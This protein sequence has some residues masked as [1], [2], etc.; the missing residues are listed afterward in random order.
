MHLYLLIY[1]YQPTPDY[2]ALPGFVYVHCTGWRQRYFIIYNI[3]YTITNTAIKI[4]YIH[5]MKEKLLKFY[6]LNMI[7]FKCFG[8]SHGK[9]CIRRI[10]LCLDNNGVHVKDIIFK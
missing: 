1:L 6:Y 4:R 3:Y 9:Y 2:T 10:R 8:K 7:S 5:E